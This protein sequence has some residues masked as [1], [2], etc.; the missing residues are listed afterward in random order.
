MGYICNIISASTAGIRFKGSCNMDLRKLAVNLVPF[1]RL[2]FLSIS[3]APLMTTQ[4][5][6]YTTI[7]LSSL[8]TQLFHEH[9]FLSQIKVGADHQFELDGVYLSAAMIFRGGA[10]YRDSLLNQ[11]EV[12]EGLRRTVREL[13]A[14][15]EALH[16]MPNVLSASTAFGASQSIDAP[17]TGTLFA[18]N[19]AVRKVFSRTLKRFRK[20]FARKAFLSYYKQH[21][22]EEADFE[23][24]VGDIEDLL[25]E[26]A[27]K[28]ALPSK[29]WHEMEAVQFEPTMDLSLNGRKRKLERNAKVNWRAKGRAYG[30]KRKRGKGKGK[31]REK[32]QRKVIIRRANAK[33]KNARKASSS[34]DDFEEV[35]SS[36]DEDDDEEEE[37]SDVYGLGGS[38]KSSEDS[39][40]S[41]STES[42]TASDST[43]SSTADSESEESENATS[44]DSEHTD[45]ASSSTSESSSLD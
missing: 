20:M 44:T 11:C 31:G 3:D 25:C 19:T 15:G 27:E 30:Q 22:T 6:K 18:N 10:Q 8:I 33:A 16:S 9:Q 17:I 41:D 36:E 4:T 2:K 24:A 12:D 43:K 42:A 13:R 14:N 37:D 40:A 1:P 28:D 5:Q 23:E 45:S 35:T 38:Q 7:T 21:G 39:S 34:S 32:M 26:Y 29:P